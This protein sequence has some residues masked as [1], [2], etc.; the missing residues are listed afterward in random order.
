MTGV[1]DQCDRIGAEFAATSLKEAA[2]ICDQE[3]MIA[4][5]P[6]GLQN[7]SSSDAEA[8]SDIRVLAN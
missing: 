3:R 5:E 6:A 1:V 2:A 4:R 8:V 7:G